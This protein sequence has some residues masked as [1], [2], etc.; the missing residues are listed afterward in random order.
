MPGPVSMNTE[1]H[2]AFQPLPTADTSILDQ[3]T[4]SANASSQGNVKKSLANLLLL[5]LPLCLALACWQLNPFSLTLVTNAASISRLSPQQKANI[6][7]A[8]KAVNGFVLAPGQTFSFNQIV[9]PR[10]SA[11]GYCN[12]PSYLGSDT[13]LTFGGGVCLL[14]SLLYRNAL[15][16]GLSI[17]E[18][19]PHTRT[20]LSVPTGMDATVWF[21]RSDLKFTNNSK[22]PLLF[23]VQVDSDSLKVEFLGSQ[24]GQS[25]LPKYNLRRSVAPAGPGKVEVTVERQDGDQLTLLSRDIYCLPARLAQVIEV[26]R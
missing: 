8:G 9:G 6:E 4:K 13:P 14:S 11:R 3:P 26:K 16:L 7:L 12:S 17:K 24:D 5:L 25:H 23:A 10:T 19:N 22:V 20:I 15:E 2:E 18:R 21:G 1:S